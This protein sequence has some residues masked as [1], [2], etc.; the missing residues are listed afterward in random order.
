[1]F[2]LITIIVPV[3][4]VE[5]YLDQ[6]IRSIVTQ[7]YDNLE[8]ILVDDGSLD[9]SSKM[10][11]FW[12]VYDCRINVIH[13]LNG[14]LSSARNAGLDIC[15]GK[16]ITFVDSD[17]WVSWDYVSTLFKGLVENNVE[18]C[19]ANLVAINETTGERK[20]INK[21]EFVADS[22]E[23][24]LKLYNENAFPVN[25]WNKL[26]CAQI[27]QNLRFPDGRNYEDAFTTYLTIDAA[28]K[29]AHLSNALYNYRVRPE[30]IMTDSF[31]LSKVDQANAWKEN[32]LFCKNKYPEIA[33]YA[34]ILWLEHIPPLLAQFPSHMSKNEKKA[35]KQL[36][37]EI[38]DNMF[39]LLFKMPLKKIYYQLKGLLY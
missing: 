16:Y 2:E 39:F 8:I 20:V 18:I 12:A 23:T 38:W 24:L 22:R 26:Y 28:N 37:S 25:S 30:S 19:S 27:W 32:Y 21:K 13:K 4:K 6:C 11:D 14:G 34:R 15:S 7:D 10:C 33:P 31:S 17:D 3:Y 36:K 9:F 1:M 29:I 5:K 35:K